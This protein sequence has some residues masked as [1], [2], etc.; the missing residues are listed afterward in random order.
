MIK[1]PPLTAHE[2]GYSLHCTAQFTTVMV[3]VA[4]LDPVLRASVRRVL[5]DQ[6]LDFVES[7]A[8]TLPA[9]D[10]TAFWFSRD[11]S[12]V[13]LVH[14]FPSS[15]PG[16]LRRAARAVEGLKVFG[17]V[18]SP[19]IVEVWNSGL[20]DLDIWA[21]AVLSDS[22]RGAVQ[23]LGRSLREA[24]VRLREN[25]ITR[26]LRRR[27]DLNDALDRSVR[28][29]ATN[30]MPIRTVTRLRREVGLSERQL[31][32]S[33]ADAGFESPSQFLSLVRCVLALDLVRRGHA[34][35]RAAVLV[36]YG[37]QKTLRR[38]SRALFGESPAAAA[39]RWSTEEL[40]DR[41]A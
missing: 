20:R 12:S 31:R 8:G 7:D 11:G 18:R 26:V 9:I 22:D 10:E 5:T 17:V 16:R 34:V 40:L 41:F 24:A 32:S 3:R 21:L 37:S 28:Q 2:S 25:E 38:H 35:A 1:I 15:N 30:P 13:L 14:D 36:G 19:A 27:F 6:G 33:V 23:D 29:V 39:K 4:V